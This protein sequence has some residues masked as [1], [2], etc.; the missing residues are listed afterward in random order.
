M[1]L[2]AQEVS[3][4][5][6]KFKNVGADLAEWESK[7]S[8]GSSPPS[9]S[10][11]QLECHGSNGRSGINLLKAGIDKSTDGSSH[12]DLSPTLTTTDWLAPE[13]LKDDFGPSPTT[14]GTLTD[15]DLLRETDLGDQMRLLDQVRRARESIRGSLD[16][17]R[18]GSPTPTTDLLS[19]ALALTRSQTPGS[20]TSTAVSRRSS[21]ASNLL[22]RPLDQPGRQRASSAAS[23]VTAVVQP[24]PMQRAASSTSVMD[25]PRFSSYMDHALETSREQPSPSP[26]TF[27]ILAPS[28]RPKST[29]ELSATSPLAEWD[30]YLSSRQVVYPANPGSRPVSLSVHTG[31]RISQPMVLSVVP[32]H[33]SKVLARKHRSSANLHAEIRHGEQT[34]SLI[35]PAFGA[36]VPTMKMA[37]SMSYEQL[38]E[39]H[40]RRLSSLQQ[41]VTAKMKVQAERSAGIH[42]SGK[43]SRIETGRKS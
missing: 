19:P 41:P 6:E 31:S 1:R 23:A 36:S 40:S 42:Q 38:N 37:R 3:R 5:A 15:Q 8:R 35:Q 18:R 12:L 43:E 32:E 7:H 13:E 27:A 22:L 2:E 30:R 17:L 26:E 24:V 29:S 34:S 10:S 39:R 21:A 20:D 11:P 4:A 16:E 14:R 33:G 9:Y 25:R 28:P